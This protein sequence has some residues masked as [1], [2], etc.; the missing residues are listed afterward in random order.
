MKKT[1]FLILTTSLT[2]LWPPVLPAD[3]LSI[4][5]NSKNYSL[6]RHIEILEDR[7][8]ELTIEEVSSPL[9]DRKFITTGPHTPNLGFTD[10]TFWVRIK[11]TLPEEYDY[12][13]QNWVIKYGW[14][15]STSITAY[16]SSGVGQFL[17]KNISN[18]ARNTPG[19]IRYRLPLLWLTGHPGETK[20]LYFRVQSLGVVILPFSLKSETDLLSEIT[21]ENLLIGAF[22]GIM[23]IMILYH[24]F[25]Y[26]AVRNRDYIYL[27]FFITAQ[28]IFQSANSGILM[29]K[30]FTYN[31]HYIVIFILF[32]MAGGFA[33]LSMSYI[34]LLNLRQ[35]LPSMEKTLYAA[36][37][38]SIIVALLSCWI[39]QKQSLK[40]LFISFLFWILLLF[41]IVII[42]LIQGSDIA[43]YFIVII[44]LS[45]TNSLTNTLI[46]FDIIPLTWLTENIR[47]MFTIVQSII[48]SY[49][50]SL[51]IQRIERD[52]LLAQ[53]LA[54]ENLRKA[55]VIKDEFLANTSHEL[56]TP[57]HGIIGIAEL[58]LAGKRET[59]STAARENLSLIANNGRRL[60]NLVNDI[61]DFSSIKHGNPAILLQP[62]DMRGAVS[63][64]FT[65]LSPLVAGK[66]ILL[67]NRVAQDFSPVYA[68][69][70][71]LKQ[72]LTNLAGNAVK[73]TSYGAVEIIAKR[74]NSGDAEITVKD[75]G[76]GIGPDD[77]ERIFNYFEQGDGSSSRGHEG[78]GLGLAITKKLVELHGGTIHVESEKGKGSSFTF[79]LP[80]A[81]ADQKSFPV[82]SRKTAS[83]QS[84]SQG[85]IKNRHAADASGCHQKDED[86]GPSILVIDDDPVSVK[87]LTEYLTENGY[88]VHAACDGYAGLAVIEEKHVDMVLL[89]IMMPGL[90]GYD[91]LQKIRKTRSRSELPVILITAKSQIDDIA[92][93]FDY[94][95]N[96]Y[97]VKPF[98]I[99][100]ITFRINTI[101]KIYDRIDTMEPGLTIIEK[102]TRTFIPYTDIVYL[103]SAGK[104]TILHRTE[105]DEDIGRLLKEME[106]RLPRHF[107]RI[108]R[109]YII[110]THF[111][112]SVTHQAGGYYKV[113]LNDEDDT[114]LPVG[115][116]FIQHL[117]HYMEKK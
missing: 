50:V 63:T 12:Q 21:I 33:L 8:G 65:L 80:F 106:L 56:K 16:V 38:L 22:Y 116:T 6:N 53:G 29:G 103:S 40:L 66:A 99:E 71:R 86:P 88:R 59:F 75:T 25:L 81:T 46:R 28:I 24:L 74:G 17:E 77:L 55:E 13:N 87:I 83:F 97:I 18:L 69:E 23:L 39:P 49:A 9:Y 54:I 96:D 60:M 94:G 115:R 68:D 51:R 90:S 111:I 101:M 108:H 42:R 107:S 34:Y 58:M 31:E 117:Q 45:L 44:A 64:V 27:L 109:K 89:D 84:P 4:T 48:L 76:K 5:E 98:H 70:E 110:N 100:E 73:F 91:V 61:L 57:L 78:T 11:I 37:S 7:T 10:S 47:P 43:L 82:V 26:L 113:H 3:P 41:I 114:C 1:L 67:Q 30:I 20:T 102:S 14:P 72:I 105:R 35:Y 52:R 15:Y 79:T 104:R 85:S 36:I 62:V 92:T 112:N 19:K 93:G 95:A 32:F 2:L